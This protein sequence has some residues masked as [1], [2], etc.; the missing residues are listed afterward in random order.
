MSDT[1]LTTEQASQQW[2]EG[3]A[4]YESGD[5]Q[6]AWRIMYGLYGAQIADSPVKQATLALQIGICCRRL[7]KWDDAASWLNEAMGAPGS[8]ADIQQMAERHLRQVRLENSSADFYDLDDGENITT[9]QASRLWE[10]GKAAYESGDF[11]T[12]WT[13][14]YGLYGT[15]VANLPVPRATLALQIG[16]CCRRLGKWDDAASWLNEAMA[17]SGADAEVKEM[18][19][20]HL[21]QV[22]LENSSAD[23]YDLDDGENIT[24]EQAS[25]LW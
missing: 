3:K 23:F 14:M 6:T 10:E 16:I 2:D 17:A 7:G 1:H 4:A 12:A 20:R 8:D 9:E 13:T 15:E 24:T 5:F 22:R 18:A 21:R 11:Q 19:E 25:R